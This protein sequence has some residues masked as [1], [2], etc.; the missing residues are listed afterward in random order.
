MPE[1]GNPNRKSHLLRLSVL[2]MNPPC[3]EARSN[4]SM[5][6]RATLHFPP[7]RPTHG[8]IAFGEECQALSCNT[9]GRTELLSIAAG[10][11]TPIVG[12]LPDPK[13]RTGRSPRTHHVGVAAILL[14]DPFEQVANPRFD[15][16]V[17]GRLRCQRSG[18]SL[19]SHD[20]RTPSDRAHRQEYH[21]PT[22][23]RIHSVR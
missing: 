8:P 2:A 17:Q 3:I 18:R 11:I 1:I 6:R 9:D 22:N 23:M 5:P 16:F 19:L 15:R 14:R 20:C 12:F 21:G 13:P 4:P 7:E 10:D